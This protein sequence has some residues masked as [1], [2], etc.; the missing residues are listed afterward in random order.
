MWATTAPKAPTCKA[1]WISTRS[2][3]AWRWPPVCTPPTATPSSPPPT[4]RASTPCGRTSDSTPSTSSETAFDSNYHSLQVNVRKSF[5]AAGQFNASYT[6]SK[7]LTDAGA[8]STAPQSSF[9]WHE[10]EYGPCPGDRTQVLTFNYVYTIPAFAHSHGVLNQALGGW[11]VSGIPT[12]YTGTPFTVTTSSVDPAGLGLLGTSASSSRPDEICNPQRQRSRTN[13]V[14]VT[15]VGKAHLVQHGLLRAGAAGR[16]P[17]R[18][19]RPRHGPRSRFLRL[20]RQPDE[21]LQPVQGRPRQD[22]SF[23]GEAFNMLNWVNPAA[24]ASTNI[25]SA[26]FGQINLPRRPPRATRRQDHVLSDAPGEACLDLQG[27][28]EGAMV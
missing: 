16:R 6:W 27:C 7:N 12:F 5:G 8:D 26:S 14:A 25:T 23:A 1:S 19:R 21:E 11:E 9:N 4:T 22:C 2:R 15:G 3:P 28:G 20:G 18:Q 24:F 13:Y 17:A 10:G